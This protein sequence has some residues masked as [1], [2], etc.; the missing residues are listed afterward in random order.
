M[1][2]AGSVP[3]QGR[4]VA[5]CGGVGGAKL[6]FGLERLLGERL[7]VVVNT[8][9]D[10]EHL[11]LHVSPDLDTVL[12]TLAGLSNRELGWGRGDESWNF[13]A[14]LGDLGGE[15]WFQLG[16]RDLALHVM[17]TAR[18]RAG[19]PLTRVIGEVARRFGVRSEIL[20]MSDA[21]VRTTMV[22][23]EGSLPFQRYFV[24]R[25]CEPVVREIVFEGAAE[26]RPTEEVE[27]AFGASDLRA[28]VIC[29]SNPFLSVDP[30]L[31]VPGIRDLI[32]QAQVPV[33]AVSPII[34]G[35]G[36]KGPIDKIMA[37]RGIPATNR[38]IAEHYGDLISGLVID[39]ADADERGSIGKPVHVTAT[40]MRSDEDRLRLAGETLVFADDLAAMQPAGVEAS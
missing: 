19:V 23:A 2:T 15:T 27:R 8:G 13:M 28:I 5:L 17:R 39:A 18:L 12:Y 7:T 30:I 14:A 21:P 25:R 29:P 31:S 33:V 3:G 9:D 11:G 10:F 26:A 16:D 22:T 24:E 32:E 36:I 37:E 6:A 38:T 4:V 40:L 20:P 1:S 34:G 35:K